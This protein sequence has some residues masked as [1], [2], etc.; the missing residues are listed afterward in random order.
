MEGNLNRG[1]DGDIATGVGEP[2]V[3][4]IFKSGKGAAAGLEPARP[5]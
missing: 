5:N 3:E 2:D 4:G 1:S